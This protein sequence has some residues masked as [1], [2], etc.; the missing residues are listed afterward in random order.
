MRAQKSL[1]TKNGP[2]TLGFKIACFPEENCFG[3][4]GGW[5]QREPPPPPPSVSK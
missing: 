2:H 4:W 3:F 1:C 5:V